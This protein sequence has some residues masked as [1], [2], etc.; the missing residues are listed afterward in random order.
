MEIVEHQGKKYVRIRPEDVDI[1]KMTMVK[2]ISEVVAGQVLK[3]VVKIITK[4]GDEIE[5]INYAREGDW[6]VYNIGSSDFPRMMDK[7]LNCD[8]KA[9]TKGN[10]SYL[11][12][13]VDPNIGISADDSLRLIN[14]LVL[15]NMDNDKFTDTSFVNN[16]KLYRYIGKA[17]YGAHVPFN[18]VVSA[19]WGEDQ[20][21]RRGG[22]L[23]YDANVNSE[24]GKELM[25]SLYG[26]EGARNRVAGEFEKTYSIV[27]KGHALGGTDR[28]V[29]GQVIADTFKIAI[30][31]DRSPIAGIQFNNVDLA[32][33]Y[34]KAGKRM[35]E[36]L[37]KFLPN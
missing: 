5:T 18:F 36:F 28:V 13:L 22:I 24:W 27:D 29:G 33:A 30:R 15:D 11:Y 37:Q 7:L 9:I 4:H 20:F 12:Q 32:M 34:D 25:R 31:C 16:L 2:K 10:F 1:S 35:P 17:V 8:R 6:V 14:E 23:I 3:G 21:I 26:I 19:P